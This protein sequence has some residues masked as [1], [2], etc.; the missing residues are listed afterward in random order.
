MPN[1]CYNAMFY[2]KR[3]FL[4][5]LTSFPLKISTAHNPA[6]HLAVRQ[7]ICPFHVP[8]ALTW[9]ARKGDGLHA[10]DIACHVP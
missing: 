9:V 6:L 4:F 7:R 5:L 3:V 8:V 10:R 1:L 2:I